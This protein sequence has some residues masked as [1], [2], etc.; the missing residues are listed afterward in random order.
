[1]LIS[2]EVYNRIESSGIYGIRRVDLRKEFG[3]DVDNH[4]NELISQGLVFVDK[5]NGAIT[6]WSKDSYLRYM[7]EKDPKLKLLQELIRDSKDKEEVI[8]NVELEEKI[9]DIVENV[10]NEKINIFN[11]ILNSEILKIKDLISNMN[12]NHSSFNDYI[13]SIKSELE[14]RFSSM[15]NKLISYIDEN[16]SIINSRLLDNN[17]ELNER[18]NMLDTQVRSIIN[19]NDMIKENREE[20]DIKIKEEISSLKAYVDAKSD[21]INMMLNEQRSFSNDIVKRLTTLEES[22]RDLEARIHKV[23]QHLDNV[24]NNNNELKEEISSISKSIDSNIDTKIS[25]AIDKI[26]TKINNLTEDLA[27]IKQELDTKLIYIDEVVRRVD[28]ILATLKAS[29]NGKNGNGTYNNENVITLE[30]FRIDFDRMLAE[31]SSSIGWVELASIRERMCRRYNISA[32]EFYTLVSQLIEHFNSRYE[33]SSGGQ[34]GIVIR[35][36]IHGFV[37][38][39]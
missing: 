28:D 30:Q 27:N 18:I 17:K 11:S 25:L 34:E 10:V 1:M 7:L 3:K 6:Y 36:L 33:L 31:L 21:S 12:S 9:K 39:V 35:G 29:T 15:H 22:I 19:L 14:T 2:S 37:R 5:K 38:R 20:L 16:I 24:I 26:H 32:H 8:D 23:N 13:S 4:V